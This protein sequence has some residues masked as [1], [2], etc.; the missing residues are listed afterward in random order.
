MLKSHPVGVRVLPFLTRIFQLECFLLRGEILDDFQ[1]PIPNTGARGEDSGFV[2]EETSRRFWALWTGHFKRSKKN[3]SQTSMYAPAI[4]LSSFPF[5]RSYCYFSHLPGIQV[6]QSPYLLLAF[7]FYSLFRWFFVPNIILA[8]NTWPR[9]RA[10]HVCRWDILCPRAG[11]VENSQT[12]SCP[13]PQD[14]RDPHTE[15]SVCSSEENLDG[16]PTQAWWDC[17]SLS[18]QTIWTPR[19]TQVGNLASNPSSA[20]TYSSLNGHEDAIRPTGVKMLLK[21]GNASKE[22]K[23]LCALPP[24]KC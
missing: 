8:F 4:A 24:W 1:Q 6:P 21:W 12:S 2:S 5:P 3:S 10:P 13:Q 22:S 19:S 20:S 9:F 17:Q 23:M 18:H 15:P 7:I 11:L 14:K 16:E